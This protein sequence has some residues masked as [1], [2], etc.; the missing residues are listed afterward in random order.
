MM[1]DCWPIDTTYFI[2]VPQTLAPK[3]LSWQLTR[4]DLRS[5]DSSTAVPSLRRPDLEGCEVVVAPRPEQDRIVAAIEEQMS[6]LDAAKS[7]LL[8]ARLRADSLRD[9][10]LMVPRK[11]AGGTATVQIGDLC[12]PG[13]KLAYG[14]LQPGPHMEDG[15]PLV[16]V[17][18]IKDLR[19]D[20]VGKRID[21]KIA[22]QYPRTRL[23][24]GEVLLSLVGTIGR[25]AVAPENLAGANV[26]RAVGVIPVA[27]GVDARYVAISLSSPL[28]TRQLSSLAHEVARKTLNL[29]DV[30][31]F[32]IP[33]PSLSDQRRIAAETDRQLSIVGTLADTVDDVLIR[34]EQL[35]RAVLELAFC[36]RLVSPDPDDEP[37]SMLL[38]RVRKAAASRT[39]RQRR[40]TAS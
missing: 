30:R 23:H 37:A 27:D 17:G 1:Y 6:R 32:A 26:A 11:L 7:L 34:T 22:Q 38:E 10:I 20:G 15:V 24:G 3:F 40:V 8:L 9:A 21:P 35:R 16:R 31:R 19:V 39:T 5:L 4:A 33:L 13:R 36:G 14:V 28:V 25:A 12:E 18:D 2:R 29:E